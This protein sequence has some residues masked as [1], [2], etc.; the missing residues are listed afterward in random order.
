MA[1]TLDN[2]HRGEINGDE[3]AVLIPELLAD[4]RKSELAP[5]V[6]ET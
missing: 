3:F 2:F 4:L 1:Q 6:T 5:P